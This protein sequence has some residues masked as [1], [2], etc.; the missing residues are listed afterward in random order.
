MRPEIELIEERHIDVD[1]DHMLRNQ[2]QLTPPDVGAAEANSAMARPTI[3]M[4]KLATAHLKDQL[5]STALLAFMYQLT[6]Q[7]IAEGPPLGME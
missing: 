5:V 4:K 6:P 3:K 1:Q 7:T 2:N